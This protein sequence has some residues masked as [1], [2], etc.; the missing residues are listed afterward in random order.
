MVIDAPCVT[1]HLALGWTRSLRSSTAI[2]GTV[3]HDDDNDRPDALEQG[4]GIRPARLLAF[5]IVHARG[6]AGVQPAQ[7]VRIARCHNG[8]R[9]PHLVETQAQG[10]G[11]EAIRQFL[12]GHDL[13]FGSGISDFGLQI[14][15]DR[16]LIAAHD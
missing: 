8:R 11:F 9:N 13:D 7:E 2:I 12:G 16:F 1:R 4:V 3:N 6:V 15:S 5:E 14:T 10:F